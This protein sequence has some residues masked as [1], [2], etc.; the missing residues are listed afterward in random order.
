MKATSM[1]NSSA[2]LKEPL[3]IF[4]SLETVLSGSWQSTKV[5]KSHSLVVS[6]KMSL[7]NIFPN[8]VLPFLCGR[9]EAKYSIVFTI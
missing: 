7:K 1:E 5:I 8:K 6:V 3:C 4:G 9:L 2:M